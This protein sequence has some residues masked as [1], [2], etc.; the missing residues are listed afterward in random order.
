MKNL[1]LTIAIS[2]FAFIGTA[3]ESEARP[4]RGG[5]G[6][7]VTSSH[8]YVSGHRHGRPV[9]TKKIFVGYDRFDRPVY[10]YKTVAGPRRGHH[11]HHA[12][13]HR[14]HRGISIHFGR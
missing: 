13:R 5:H 6:H 12:P 8:T 1:L 11:H 10:K 14:L 3:V 7:E 2:A 9:Y 4:Y